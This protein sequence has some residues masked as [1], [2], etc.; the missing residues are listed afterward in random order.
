MKLAKAILRA[1]RVYIA[2]NGGSAANA[3]HI[4]N[5]LISC[6]IRAYPLTGDVATLTAI[7]ND[8][9]YENIFSHQIKVFGE[10]GDLLIVLSG[11]GRSENIV[12]AIN[13]AK[14]LSMD[15]FSI[16][17]EFNDAP[18]AAILASRCIKFGKTMQEAEEKQLVLGHKAMLWIKAECAV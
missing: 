17:G 4:A 18:P 5:D 9:G 8:F 1:K 12:N 2:G 11:S 15:T 16:V 3:V 10:K 7:A 6:G 14:S 13:M